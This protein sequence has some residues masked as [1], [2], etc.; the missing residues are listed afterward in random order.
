MLY[1]RINGSVRK[2]ISKIFVLYEPYFWTEVLRLYNQFGVRNL[3]K[4]SKTFGPYGKIIFHISEL[5]YDRRINGIVRKRYEKRYL[6]R[7]DQTFWRIMWGWII[8]L[9]YATSHKPP[10]LS[11]YMEQIYF[12]ISSAVWTYRRECKQKE[13]NLDRLH[14]TIGKVLFRCKW[15]GIKGHIN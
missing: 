6:F 7:I 12:H 11:V 3:I 1:D 15:I 10:K 14:R 13:L 9:D 8:N 5:L 2:T 4:S